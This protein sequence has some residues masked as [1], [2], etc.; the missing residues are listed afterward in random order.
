MKPGLHLL[1]DDEDL[2][3]VEKPAGV[4]TIPD[5]FDPSKPNLLA[6]L[7]EAFGAIWVVHRLD[8]ETSGLVCFA[9]NEEAHR[10]LNLQFSERTVDKVY[11]ALTDGRPLPP[12]GSIEQPIAPHPGVAGKMMI[13]RQG[14]YALTLY[15]VADTFRSFSLVEANIKTGRTHQIRV[16]LSSIGHPLAVDPIYGKRAELFLSEIKLRN[17]RTGK[18]EPERPL[19]SRL[20][21]HALNLGITH[22]RSG[23]RLVVE[24]PLPKD[25]RALLN[26]L[27]KWGR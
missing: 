21:L 19:M 8:R 25:F 5:R 7:Q 2:L 27:D 22:P 6:M 12:S 17:F 20:T 23:E 11:L 16:H 1:Y 18:E 13:H 14:K 24:S 15:R 3:V 10:H 9:K 4:L 26:Q